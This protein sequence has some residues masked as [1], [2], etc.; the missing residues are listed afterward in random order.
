MNPHLVGDLHSVS[1]QDPFGQIGG[2]GSKLNLC[3][4]IRR[5]GVKAGPGIGR[6]HIFIGEQVFKRSNG[7]VFFTV[8]EGEKRQVTQI[9]L[10]DFGHV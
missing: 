1:H 10:I 3:Q 2:T 9:P 8:R 5:D 7:L 6:E 4:C